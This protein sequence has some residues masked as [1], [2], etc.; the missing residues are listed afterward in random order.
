M[1]KNTNY[2]SNFGTF[3]VILSS[4][5][6]FLGLILQILA[7]FLIISLFFDKRP[8][9]HTRFR[10]KNAVKNREEVILVELWGIGERIRTF[11]Q[12]IYHCFPFP[13]G[14]ALHY[15]D[16][17]MFTYFKLT[18]WTIILLNCLRQITAQ[19]I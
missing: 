19:A 17:H 15:C 9:A 2:N 4:F 3:S 16:Q 5:Q 11:G 12:N 14:Y 1:R 13:S 6:H 7:I 8:L 10:D 18:D